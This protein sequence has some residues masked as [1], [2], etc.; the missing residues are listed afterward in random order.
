MSLKVF[1]IVVTSLSGRCYCRL[2]N[3][4]VVVSSNVVRVQAD[5]GCRVFPVT[6]RQPAGTACCLEGGGHQKLSLPGCEVL[7]CL[8]FHCQTTGIPRLSQ[9]ELSSACCL[10][11]LGESTVLVRCDIS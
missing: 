9:A 2:T 4:I 8:C 3:F 1:Q 11:V 10:E 5:K 6:A 7:V